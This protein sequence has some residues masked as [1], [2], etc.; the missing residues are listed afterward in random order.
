MTNIAN[1]KPISD[2]IKRIEGA[3]LKMTAGNGEGISKTGGPFDRMHQELGNIVA[4]LS[5]NAQTGRLTGTIEQLNELKA[6]LERHAS[7]I[8]SQE[9]LERFEKDLNDACGLARELFIR[10]SNERT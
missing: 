1:E 5:M 9:A 2:L 4:V 10:R 3:E 7:K 6:G 8:E